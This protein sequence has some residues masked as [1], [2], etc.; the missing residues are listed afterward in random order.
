MKRGFPRNHVS[1]FTPLLATLLLLAVGGPNMA[2]GLYA[3]SSGAPCAPST[4][5]RDVFQAGEELT[6]EVSYLG[7]ALGSIRTRVTSIDSSKGSQR[8][9]TECLIRTYRGI[10]FVTLNTLFQS[11][12]GDSLNTV[13]FRNKEFLA[14]HSVFKYIEYTFPKNRNQVYISEVVDRHPEW[15]KSDTL[16]LEGKRWQDG[17]SLFFFARAFSHSRQQCNVPVL[18]YDEKAIT[19]IRFGVEVEEEDI[20]AVDYDIRC[21]KLEGETGFTGIFGLTG[22][23]EGWFSDDAAAVPIRA[24]MHVYVGSVKIELIKWK[25]Q[26]WKPPRAK[27]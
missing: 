22:G 27:D 10:P 20:D 15:T 3:Q 4:A 23:F 24:K 7:I 5:G 25:R 19:K 11:V 14:D 17:L 8:I 6:Y 9:A 13:F 1:C 26:G 16:D 21:R 18:M 12:V 2:G